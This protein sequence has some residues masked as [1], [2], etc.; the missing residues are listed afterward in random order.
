[1]D[2]LKINKYKNR[3]QSVE[4]LRLAPNTKT[5]QA[6]CILQHIISKPGINFGKPDDKSIAKHRR[7]KNKKHKSTPTN[8]LQL[9]GRPDNTANTKHWIKVSVKS[10]ENEPLKA[11]HDALKKTETKK[12]E[13]RANIYIQKNDDWS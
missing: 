9:K 11:E 2:R 12:P 13:R 8:R 1:M 6:S 3:D 4:W 7:Q 10:E 5:E